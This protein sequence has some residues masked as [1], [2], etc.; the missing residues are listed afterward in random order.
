[1]FT[2]AESDD[3]NRMEASQHL[4]APVEPS[5]EEALRMRIKE[6]ELQLQAKEQQRLLGNRKKTRQLLK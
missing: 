4:E 5:V 1:M 6:L 3:T 2:A